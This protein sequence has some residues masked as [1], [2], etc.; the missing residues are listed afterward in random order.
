MCKHEILF[1]MFLY[2][3]ENKVIFLFLGNLRISLKEIENEKK[4]KFHGSKTKE[5]FETG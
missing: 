4:N 2:V 1:T 3:K 5:S